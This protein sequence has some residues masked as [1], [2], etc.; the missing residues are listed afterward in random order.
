VTP[1][2]A[3]PPSFAEALLFA[4]G[5]EVFAFP[6]GRVRQVLRACWPQPIPRPPLGCLGVIE[7]STEVV[8][9]LD[10]AVLLALRRPLPAAELPARLLDTH[11]LLVDEEEGTLGF[12]S[13]RVLEVGDIRALEEAPSDPRVAA[14]GRSASWVVGLAAAGDRRALV[15]DP[16]AVVTAS[17]RRLL[18]RAVL[19]KAG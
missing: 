5:A 19:R 12:W 8:P 7:V 16:S 10:L 15:L 9:I 2:A 6:I 11:F 4:L 3:A 1:V 17:R 18:R 13:D 14:L